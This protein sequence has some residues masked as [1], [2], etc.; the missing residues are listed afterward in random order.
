MPL[1]SRCGPYE[2]AL[3][4]GAVEGRSPL[5]HETWAHVASLVDIDLEP[6][7]RFRRRDAARE[8]WRSMVDLLDENP[9]LVDE[10]VARL[11]DSPATA[12]QISGGQRGNS[13]ESWGWNWSAS[14]T[15]LEWAWRCG[16]V[17]VAGRTASFEKIYALPE[18]VLPARIRAR[19]E[20]TASQGH[21]ELAA[22]AAKALGVFTP[23]DLADYFRTRRRPTDAALA[24][25]ADEGFVEPVRVGGDP[26]WWMCAGSALPRRMAA[27]TLVSPFD[28]VIFRR[29]RALRLHDLDYRIEIYVPR[30]R[31]RFGYYCLPF[32]LGQDFVARVDLRADRAAG[33]LEIASAW[34]EPGAESAPAFPGWSTVAA[35][36]AGHLEEVARWRGLG[37]IR[38]LDVGDLAEG[39]ARSTD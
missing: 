14:K 39:L 38:V 27:C 34:R 22:R 5:L 25:L 6:A 36:L 21:R 30:A 10:V 28:P 20:L 18:Q 26:G 37:R 33:E 13:P 35:A 16:R 1:F 12:R 24:S 15:A 32:L 8:A 31:R 11:A 29:E 7:L 17:A 2:P 9:R 19:P 4:T 23:A 3:L